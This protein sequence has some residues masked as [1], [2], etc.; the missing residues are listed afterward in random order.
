[1]SLLGRIQED[2]HRPGHGRCRGLRTYPGHH[3]HLPGAEMRARPLRTAIP[4]NAG[5]HPGDSRPG[6]NGGDNTQE[7]KPLPLPGTRHLLAPHH[8]QLRR[9]WRGHPRHTKRL[10]PRGEHRLCLQHRH[11]LRRGVDSVCRHTRATVFDTHTQG[12]AGHGHRVGD[13]GTVEPC[14]HGLLWRVAR[15]SSAATPP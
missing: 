15:A 4:A 9:A 1:M 6:A 7:S 14:L 3:R 5:L 13:R 12:H 2:R 8:H 11:R 10:Q